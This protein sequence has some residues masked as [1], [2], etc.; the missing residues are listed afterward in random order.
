METWYVDLGK[1]NLLWLYPVSLCSYADGTHNYGRTKPWPH[2]STSG[3]PNRL[4][5]SNSVWEVVS[6]KMFKLKMARAW[7]DFRYRMEVML[8]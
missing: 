4:Q 5:K 7:N 1:A 3:Q 2:A 8:K 6:D